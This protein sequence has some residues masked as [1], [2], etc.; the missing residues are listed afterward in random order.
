MHFCS[1]SSLLICTLVTMLINCWYVTSH[2]LWYALA[3]SDLVER[4]WDQAMT[5]PNMLTHNGRI[6][7]LTGSCLGLRQLHGTK[8]IAFMSLFIILLYSNIINVRTPQSQPRI[9]V[10]QMK[11][12]HRHGVHHANVVDCIKS[13]MD[14]SLLTPLSAP[15]VAR[16]FFITGAEVPRLMEQ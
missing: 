4:C 10:I 5:T 16:T 8:K 12:T 7:G 9:D 15:T 1:F 14:I 3:Q 2:W 6:F 13:N 11:M